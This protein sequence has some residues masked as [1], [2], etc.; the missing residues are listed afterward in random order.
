MSLVNSFTSELSNFEY[1][2]KEDL[3]D[4]RQELRA[5]LNDVNVVERFQT[6]KPFER[7]VFAEKFPAIQKFKSKILDESELK[8]L[9][10]DQ[11][12]SGQ[13]VKLFPT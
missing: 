11:R 1:R 8:E 13:Q 7:L 6:E 9:L 3:K 12:L 5:V 4:F 10:G 2:Q